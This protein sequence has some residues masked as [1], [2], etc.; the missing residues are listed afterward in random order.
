MHDNGRKPFIFIVYQESDVKL[1]NRLKSLFQ[2]WGYV[3]FHCRQLER[4]PGDYRDD[5]RK[6]IS[7]CDVVVLLLSREFRWS[8]YCQAEAGSAMVL[9]KPLV[10]IIV[11][12][13][14]REEIEHDNVAPV[15]AK[16]ECISTDDKKLAYKLR[17][18][19]DKALRERTKRLR[20]LRARL[21]ALESDKLQ[22]LKPLDEPELM[23]RR[24][25]VALAIKEVAEKYRLNQPKKAICSTWPSLTNRGCHESIVGNIRKSLKRR[26]EATTLVFVGVSLKYS[27]S[28]ISEALQKEAL[29]KMGP[30]GAGETS[31]TKRLRIKLVHM[32]SQSHILHA[33]GDTHDI[34]NIRSKFE[35]KWPKI[36]EEWKKHCASASIELEVPILH[37]IDYI[38]PRIGILIDDEILYAGR[39]SFNM[40]YHDHIPLDVVMS[41]APQL[42]GEHLEFKLDVGENEYQFYKKGDRGF[43]AAIR[44]FKGSVVAYCQAKYNAGITPI[45]EPD[46]WIEH[47]RTYIRAF[48]RIH[49]ITFISATSTKFE[50]LVQEA[51]EVGA[52]MRIYIHDAGSRGKAVKDLRIKL[53]K[54]IGALADDAEILDYKHSPTY[55]AVV[56]G[57]VAIGL[58]PYVSG[59]GKSAAAQ[60]I[61]K[62]PLCLIITRCFS[63]FAELKKSVLTL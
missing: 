30:T 56:I 16:F 62:L 47:L 36:H 58:Q 54:N 14:T 23:T 49:E 44:E 13:A 11:A 38:P 52:K 57:D 33:M 9:E 19:L 42:A 59:N 60:P 18:M 8:P 25:K 27:L 5:L 17:H 53:K 2:G 15:L 35:E 41:G 4:D 45:W 31:P 24:Q 51:L 20:D 48:K 26:G 32:D 21:Q 12:P 34:D 55:R 40:L 10:P 1:A 3:A 50:S 39:C 22:P 63:E 7:R 61:K 6:K 46:P 37:R 43:D 29:A 28:L